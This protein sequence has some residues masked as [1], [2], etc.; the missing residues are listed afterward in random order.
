[1]NQNIKPYIEHVKGDTGCIVTGYARIPLVYLNSRD[2]I[3]LDSGLSRDGDGIVQLLKQERLCVRAVLTTHG[4]PDH[5]GNHGLLRSAFD[6]ELYMSPYVATIC[7]DPVNRLVGSPTFETY[8]ELKTHYPALFPDE[9]INWRDDSITVEGITFQILQ[10]PGHAPE[11]M[12]FVTPDG[13]AYL[14]DAVLTEPVLRALRLT[15]CS[16]IMPDLAAKEQIAEM[17][18]DRYILAHNGVC[19][20]IRDLALQNRDSMLQKITMVERLL[21]KAQTM[22]TLVRSVL[23]ETENDLSSLR[24][25]RGTHHNVSA[26]VSYL[27]DVGRVKKDINDGLIQYVSLTK[28]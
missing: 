22:E 21:S 4:H 28:G 7:S 12:G 5:I 14:S 15:F 3:L 25:I 13:V 17:K 16:C 26:I 23:I 11:Q 10:L 19:D 18:Y 24:K 1:M 8:L 2:V 20:E 27:M 6:C 9:L